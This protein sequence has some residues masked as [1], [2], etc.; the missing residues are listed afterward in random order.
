MSS[1][2]AMGGHGRLQ[3]RK[4][5]RRHRDGRWMSWEVGDVHGS[6]M[7]WEVRVDDV[8]GRRV[9]MDDVMGTMVGDG[10]GGKG[11][12]LIRRIVMVPSMDGIDIPG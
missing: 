2:D 9:W 11:V 12:G 10:H 3:V 5:E 7:S 1:S 4:C 8:M 6:I